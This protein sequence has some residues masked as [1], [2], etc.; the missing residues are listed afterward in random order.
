MSSG[1]WG[2]R[3]RWLQH[4]KGKRGK[5]KGKREEHLQWVKKHSQLAFLKNWRLNIGPKPLLDGG[6]GTPLMLMELSQSEPAE[7]LICSFVFR[8][9]SG[10]SRGGLKL[11]SSR[12]THGPA[13]IMFA[14][15]WRW[16]SVDP[17]GPAVKG[18]FLLWV[19]VTSIKTANSSRDMPQPTSFFNS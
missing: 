3:G 4:E 2:D 13:G 15:A 17:A 18:S 16:V 5:E 1:S 19:M 9:Q 11:Y 14:L 12:S 10:W 6:S 8:A 7:K